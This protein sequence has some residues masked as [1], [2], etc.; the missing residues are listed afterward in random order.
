MSESSDDGDSYIP[1]DSDASSEDDVAI[2]SKKPGRLPKQTYTQISDDEDE[3]EETPV[4]SSATGVINKIT[5]PD[6]D[7]GSGESSNKSEQK[8]KDVTPKK[9][10]GPEKKGKQMASSVP[11]VMATKS[12]PPTILVQPDHI[13][14]TGDVATIGRVSV[15]ERAEFPVTLDIKGT[16]LRGTPQR[17][18][19]FAVI[20]I[21]A[22]T[23]VNPAQAKIT[24]LANTFVEIQKED[25]HLTETVF[26]GDMDGS[27]QE[28]DKAEDVAGAKAT[29]IAL[30]AKGKKRKS[31]AK[32]S[33]AKKAPRS[34]GKTTARAART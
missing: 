3:E 31:S 27:D 25:V 32:K 19:T 24:H 17:C 12:L 7:F 8:S 1:E 21:S 30:P 4:G 16:L 5:A 13:D 11:V 33:S 28:Y 14:L 18:D 23:K 15:D 22:E 2:V 10:P 34:A 6:Q 29:S 9:A 26:E 20:E